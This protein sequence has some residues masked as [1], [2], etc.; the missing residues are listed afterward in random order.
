VPQTRPQRKGKRTTGSIVLLASPRER[1]GTAKKQR[2]SAKTEK[3]PL[4]LNEVTLAI[5]ADH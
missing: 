1:R 3:G 2:C 4:K 5:K